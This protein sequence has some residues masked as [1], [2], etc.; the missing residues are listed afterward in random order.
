MKPTEKGYDA[1]DVVAFLPIPVIALTLVLILH[2]AEV[3]SSGI[4]LYPESSRI[5]IHA[6]LIATMLMVAYAFAYTTIPFDIFW[7]YLGLKEL[8]MFL[9]RKGGRKCRDT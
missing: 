7:N 5:W 2:V 9:S 1:A 4:N 8:H 3:I 6:Y